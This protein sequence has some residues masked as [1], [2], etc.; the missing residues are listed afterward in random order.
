[1]IVNIHIPSPEI[2]AG[3]KESGLTQYNYDD[4][5]AVAAECHTVAAEHAAAVEAAWAFIAPHA[6]YLGW[7]RYLPGH[8]ERLYAALSVTDATAEK[9]GKG[10][11]ESFP[12][13]KWQAAIKTTR[14]QTARIYREIA[15]VTKA[16]A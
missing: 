7:Q 4:V 8:L 3:Y 12:V 6:E 5:V 1:M 9:G 15:V 16:V 14:A 2:V 11:R 13:K 10:S